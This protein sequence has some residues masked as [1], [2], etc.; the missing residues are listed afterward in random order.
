[1]AYKTI[2]NTTNQLNNISYSECEGHGIFIVNFSTDQ[3][4]R[5]KY[6]QED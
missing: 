2:K 5:R 1:M 4:F 6:E 3:D